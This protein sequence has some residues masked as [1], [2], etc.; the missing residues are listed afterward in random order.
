MAPETDRVD[1]PRPEQYH[2]E[3]I[4]AAFHD[5]YEDQAADFGYRT[6]EA[7]AV[8]WADVP[9]N[10]RALMVATA[11]RLLDDLEIAP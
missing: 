5:A 1:D 3:R 9:A 8:P 7:T 11:R 10:N 4:A 6:R 2:A